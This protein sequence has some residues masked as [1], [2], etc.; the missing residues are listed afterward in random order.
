[1]P[2]A[3]EVFGGTG[4]YVSAH[5]PMVPPQP[6][7]E[8]QWGPQETGGS[9]RDLVSPPGGLVLGWDS[10]METQEVAMVIIS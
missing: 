10:L 5:S 8:P 3:S 2:F 9:S 6:S 7:I 4:G 1:M